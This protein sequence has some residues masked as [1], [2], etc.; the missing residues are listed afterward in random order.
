MHLPVTTS[1][2]RAAIYNAMNG[3]H[4]TYVDY[5]GNSAPRTQCN[6][7]VARSNGNVRYVQIEGAP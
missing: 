4:Y 7:W 3:P 1:E 6:G 5:V 2:G